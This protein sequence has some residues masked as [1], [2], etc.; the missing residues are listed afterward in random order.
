MIDGRAT[1]IMD[2][3]GAL[4]LAT[5]PPTDELKRKPPMGRKEPLIRNEVMTPS[6]ICFEGTP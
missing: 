6:Q 5:K 1:V 3:L 2:T 4:A